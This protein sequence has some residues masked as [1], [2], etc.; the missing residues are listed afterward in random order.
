MLFA[1]QLIQIQ[2][3]IRLVIFVIKTVGIVLWFQKM[4]YFC[5]YKQIYNQT[6]EPNGY[7][8]AGRKM[9]KSNGEMRLETIKNQMNHK[10]IIGWRDWD[11]DWPHESGG[12]PTDS[13]PTYSLQDSHG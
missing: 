12:W 9:M 3:I 13:W 11:D 2:T 10:Q 1:N 6:E 4:N 7:N 5:I 8:L